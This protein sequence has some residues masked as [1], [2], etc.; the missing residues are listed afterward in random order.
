MNSRP[1]HFIYFWV[2][3]SVSALIW[4]VADLLLEWLT[5]WYAGCFPADAALGLLVVCVL[6]VSLRKVPRRQNVIPIGILCLSI[7]AYFL[8]V[9]T[10]RVV[11][12]VKVLWALP[13]PKLYPVAIDGVQI[14]GKNVGR[15]DELRPSWLLHY[16]ERP[17]PR[18]TMGHDSDD[19]SAYYQFLPSDS[20]L[21]SYYLPL[22]RRDRASVQMIMAYCSQ[23][24]VPLF[25]NWYVCWKFPMG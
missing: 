17:P 4:S 15:L 16:V 22:Q 3:V 21:D 2:V 6:A 7:E 11:A 18:R 8:S 5:T 24:E 20:I 1:G 23:H 10:S 13:D 14:W 9:P 19:Y 25:S 12:I